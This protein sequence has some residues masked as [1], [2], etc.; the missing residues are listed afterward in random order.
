MDGRSAPLEYGQPGGARTKLYLSND[1][2]SDKRD[3]SSDCHRGLV[4]CLPRR[5]FPRLVAASVECLPGGRLVRTCIST[6]WQSLA[7]DRNSLH[8]ELPCRS[9]SWTG[10]KRQFSGLESVSRADI[11][12]TGL[13]GGW[14]VR[15]G[16]RNCSNGNHTAWHYGSGC[17]VP[18]EIDE[19][20]VVEASQSGWPSWWFWHGQPEQEMFSRDSWTMSATIRNIA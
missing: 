20:Q 4:L 8:L 12:G 18:D 14:C 16:R 11:A 5:C 7:A 2:V 15:L 19:G 13:A 9:S 3:G 6:V 1:T 10:N 17:P